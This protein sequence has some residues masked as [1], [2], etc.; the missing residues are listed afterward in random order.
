[1]ESPAYLPGRGELPL[2]HDERLFYSTE[3]PTGTPA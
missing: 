2:V 1:M 3:D